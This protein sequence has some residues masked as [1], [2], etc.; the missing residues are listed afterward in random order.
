MLVGVGDAR[1][2][3]EE[4]GLPRSIIP[5]C[6]RLRATVVILDNN[7]MRIK[8]LQALSSTREIGCREL[9]LYIN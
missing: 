1:I 8:Y 5:Y 7:Q 6:V 4:D 3:R 2:P 9:L